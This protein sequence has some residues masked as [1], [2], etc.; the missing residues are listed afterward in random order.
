MWIIRQHRCNDETEVLIFK[1]SHLCSKVLFSLFCSLVFHRI[2][3][4]ID[5]EGGICASFSKYAF[6]LF[7]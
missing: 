6:V 5:G 1:I 4:M 7:F 2:T 3:R